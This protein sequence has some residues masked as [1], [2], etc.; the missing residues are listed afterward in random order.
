LILVFDFVGNA[1]YVLP[2]DTSVMRPVRREALD[3]AWLEHYFEWQREAGRPDRLVQ[4]AGVKPLPYK[5]WL[6]VSPGDGYREYRVSPVSPALRGVLVAFVQREFQASVLPPEGR[7]DEPVLL[8]VGDF[9]VTV[10]QHEDE[11][12]VY[13]ARDQGGSKLVADIAQR[14]DRELATGAHDALFVVADST[15]PDDDAGAPDAPPAGR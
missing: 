3:R 8:K 11:V 15:E 4:R 12:V 14:F 13:M 2:F 1:S 10:S 5:G 9:V 6:T 7:P